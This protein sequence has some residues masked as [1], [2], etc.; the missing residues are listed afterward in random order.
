VWYAA[1]KWRRRW[2]SFVFVAIGL[3]VLVGVAYLH[4]WL[5]IWTN[6]RINLPVLRSM[7]YPYIVL[8]GLVGVYIACL[9]RHRPGE[10]VCHACRYDLTGLKLPTPCPECGARNGFNR[11]TTATPAR[12]EGPAPA[13]PQWSA[14]A[15]SSSWFRSSGR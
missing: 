6:G 3:L 12:Q 13:S 15:G 9:P 14:S 1:A 8:V 5:S 10:N 11:A 4:Y 7:L 2:P